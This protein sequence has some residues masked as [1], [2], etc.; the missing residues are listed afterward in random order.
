MDFTLPTTKA[1]MYETLAE[2]Y[3][4]YKLAPISFEPIELPTLSLTKLNYV[5]LTDAELTA[6]ATT[7]L[8]GAHTRELALKKK[9]ISDEIKTLQEKKKLLVAEMDADIASTE[10]DYAES[11]RK[12]A[13]EAV[14]NGVYYSDASLR[15]KYRQEKDKNADIEKIRQKYK[16]QIADIEAKITQKTEELDGADDFYQTIF[17]AEISSKVKEL[18]EADEEKAKEITKYNTELSQKEQNSACN[19]AKTMKKY[20]IDFLAVKA[21]GF[22]KD[23]L[24][25]NG[26]YK[27]VLKCVT[28][29]YN[30]LSAADAYNDIMSDAGLA[31]YLD[32]YFDDILVMYKLKANEN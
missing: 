21:K 29:Y 12:I 6:A 5:P 28:A 25:N 31:P 19:N 9:E 26:Y 22:S 13:V 7:I 11:E 18:K 2:I 20:E 17:D 30:T 15:E 16:S 10:E 23:E 4:H 14:K 3:T 24:V 27:D 8:S 1:E 32:D